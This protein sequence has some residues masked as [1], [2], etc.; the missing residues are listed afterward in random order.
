M[1]TGTSDQ[2]DAMLRHTAPVSVGTSE[3]SFHIRGFKELSLI[4]VITNGQR[5]IGGSPAIWYVAGSLVRT[6]SNDCR[7]DK[8]KT[9]KL[10][11]ENIQTGVR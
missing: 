4:G 3:Y 9:Y 5:Q 6:H 10:L 2:Q 1:G 7:A 11:R 8:V